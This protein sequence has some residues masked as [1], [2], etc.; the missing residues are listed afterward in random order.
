MQTQI[1][2][3]RKAIFAKTAKG[4]EEI[5]RR[6][7]KL[8]PRQRRALILFDGV[9]NLETITAMATGIIP[10][11]ELAE[12]VSTL[13]NHGFIAPANAVEPILKNKEKSTLLKTAAASIAATAPETR[14][15]SL[16][17]NVILT[18]DPVTVRQVKDFM[19]T[20]AHT[21]LGL[22]SAEVIHR[23]E[24]A[25]DAAQL[26]TVV[27][28]WHMALRDSKQGTRFAGPYLEKVK[29]SLSNGEAID[30]HD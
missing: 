20:T 18:Q 22:L 21:Y 4:H 17:N 5:A 13:T 14:S 1:F 27:G 25:K 7:H 8:N 23:I 6:C 15:A 12:A 2:H 29:R 24:R 11:A 28:H 16:A 26:M 19:T 3:I 30:H 9:K 10:H